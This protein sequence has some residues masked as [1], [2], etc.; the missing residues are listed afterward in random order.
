MNTSG[1]KFA[2]LSMSLLGMPIQKGKF[3]TDLMS[4]IAKKKWMPGEI[5]RFF[6][7]GPNW[8]FSD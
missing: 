5:C 2:K 6:R 4:F 8:P 3:T 7:T 1:I